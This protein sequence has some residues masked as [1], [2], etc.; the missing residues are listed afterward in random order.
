MISG[1]LASTR[2]AIER[3]RG[4]VRLLGD[5]DSTTRWMLEGI[6]ATQEDHEQYLGSLLETLSA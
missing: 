3:Y 6:I 2:I 1:D 4:M 5:D